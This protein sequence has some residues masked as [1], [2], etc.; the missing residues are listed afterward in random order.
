M[1]SQIVTEFRDIIR[2]L[3]DIIY[4]LE[5]VLDVLTSN[6]RRF[7]MWIGRRVIFDPSLLSPLFHRVL[8]ELLRRKRG[9]EI[10]LTREMLEELEYFIRMTP[11]QFLELWRID[12]R[13]IE[14]IRPFFYRLS[15]KIRITYMPRGAEEVRE[16]IEHAVLEEVLS[17]YHPPLARRFARFIANEISLALATEY[18]IFCISTSPWRIVEFF[19]KIGGRVRE[20]RVGLEEKARMLKSR[21]FIRVALAASL[22]AA[23]VY[24]TTFC[25][26][27]AIGTF[28]LETLTAIIING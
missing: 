7:P 25:P 24:V 14:L 15:E 5:D 9:I 16:L 21:R 12:P 27:G 20:L 10:V 22:N 13:Y 28:G 23:F 2:K 26:L 17:E 8:E 4:L 6:L 11:S 3:E 19:K 18:P 1:T